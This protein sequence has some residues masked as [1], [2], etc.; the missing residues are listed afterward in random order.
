MVS[1]VVN[2]TGVNDCG[3]SGSDEAPA[4]GCQSI[5]GWCIPLEP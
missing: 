5:C 4:F 3:L 1:D 2:I